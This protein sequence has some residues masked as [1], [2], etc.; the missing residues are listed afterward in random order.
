[1]GNR[2]VPG[3]REVYVDMSQWSEIRRRVL[4]EGASKWQGLGALKEL[5]GQRRARPTLLRANPS[6]GVTGAL[7]A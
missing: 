3:D 6:A 2:G 7:S 4:V 5:P 1:M